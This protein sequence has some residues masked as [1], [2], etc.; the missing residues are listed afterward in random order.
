MSD[1]SIIIVNVSVSRGGPLIDNGGEI[2]NPSQEYV[3]GIISPSSKLELRRLNCGMLIIVVEIIEMVDSIVDTLILV[4]YVVSVMLVVDI[5]C[6]VDDF[7]LVMVVE[8]V[9]VTV[10]ISSSMGK[11]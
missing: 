11:T 9:D 3:D 2:F 5:M 6:E 7:V 8:V 10:I 4:K 1:S